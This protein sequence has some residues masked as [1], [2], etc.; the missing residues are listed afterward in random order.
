MAATTSI[1]SNTQI[2]MDEKNKIEENDVHDS[3]SFTTSIA[4]NSILV[5][6]DEMKIG[7]NENWKT[8]SKIKFYWHFYLPLTLGGKSCK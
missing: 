5:G 3:I 1:S 6:E 8:T 7:M 2:V 4:S